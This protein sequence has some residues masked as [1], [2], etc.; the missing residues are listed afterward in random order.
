MRFA[1]LDYHYSALGRENATAAS[2]ARWHSVRPG[3]ITRWHASMAASLLVGLPLRRL[4]PAL[5]AS[6]L[7]GVASRGVSASHRG[8]RLC[9]DRH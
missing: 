8:G 3:R 6:V 5:A 7:C 1:S 4:R 2:H 9:S